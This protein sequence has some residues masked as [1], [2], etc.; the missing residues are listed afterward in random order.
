MGMT[1]KPGRSEL[2]EDRPVANALWLQYQHTCVDARRVFG[3]GLR[4]R[5]SMTFGEAFWEV[6]VVVRTVG[7]DDAEE[8]R[9]SRQG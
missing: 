6:V 4:G 7:E 9:D 3:R 2:W 1:E 5:A 8:R